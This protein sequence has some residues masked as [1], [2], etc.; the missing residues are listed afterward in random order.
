MSV[1]SIGARGVDTAAPAARAVVLL[2]ALLAV[3]LYL[4]VQ[5][6]GLLSDDYSLLFAFHPAVTGSELVARVAGMFAQ[7]VGRRA[8]STGRSRWRRS[9]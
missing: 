5:R 8:S 7:G 3:L 9:R 2:P 4:P 6:T 1:A